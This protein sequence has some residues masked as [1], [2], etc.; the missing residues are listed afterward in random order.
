MRDPDYVST[1][2]A[3]VMIIPQVETELAL[4]NLEDIVTAEGI[5]AVFVGPMDLS[6]SLGV[7]RQFSS[8]KFLKAVEKVVST[9]KAHNV[10]PGLLAPAGPVEASIQ[11]GFK[12]IQL[13]GD[14][15]FLTESVATALK[16]ARS[17]VD[18]LARKT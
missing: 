10:S 16:N 7:F 2:N 17:K 11:Q 8:P 6:L 12:M 14:L 4:K 15:G 9:C 13:G 5:D 3:E 18:T 1:A